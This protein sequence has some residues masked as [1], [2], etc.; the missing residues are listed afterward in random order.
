MTPMP[1]VPTAPPLISI[2]LCTYNGARYLRE[3][4]DSLLSQDW[5]QLE[6]VAVDDV[7]TD[8]TPSILQAYAGRH[9]CIRYFQNT[10]NLGYQKNFERA[11]RECRGRWIAPCDQDDIWLPHKLSRLAQALDDGTSLLAFCDS[12]LIDHHGE[13]LERKL[14]DIIALHST[15][16]PLPFLRSNMVSGHAML[17]CRSLLDKGLPLPA[18]LFHDWWLAYVAVSQAPIRYV[19]ACL[20][21]YRQHAA[22]VT[23]ISGRKSKTR[24]PILKQGY[25]AR[26]LADDG[27]RIALLSDVAGKGQAEALELLSLWKA[28]EHQWL[29]WRLAWFLWSK[30]D[31]YHAMTNEALVFKKRKAS[32]FFWGLRIKRWVKAFRY[33]EPKE[34]IIT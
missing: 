7:S 24:K 22:S 11:M 32:S 21:Q 12:E 2:A 20:V 17:F 10:S 23:D 14:S 26:Q 18:E 25:R 8:E 31:R 9:S 30:A 16:D 34:R 3:Q 6:I 19:D 29:S 28:R 5:P 27:V 15:D 33:R 4:L 13:S 1:S